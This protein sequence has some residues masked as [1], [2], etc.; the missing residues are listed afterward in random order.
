VLNWGGGSSC[1]GRP[2]SGDYM[3][4]PS[5]TGP[6]ALPWG[7]PEYL[8]LGFLSFATIILIELF[9]SPAMRNASIVLGLL[10]PLIVAGPLGYMSRSTIDAAP[11][12]TF[13]WTHTFKL[14]VYGPAVLP[15]L[16]VY[17][18]LMAEAIGDCTATCEVSRQKVE[19]EEF[20][21]RIAGAVLS[22]GLGG[23][24]S[25][26]FTTAP[27]S[28]FAQNNGVIAITRIANRRAG[29][30]CC[31]WL[32]LLGI[33]GKFSGAI[34]AIP[35][36]TL[37]GVTTFLFASVAVSGLKILSTVKYTRRN[38]FILAGSLTFGLGNLLVPDWYSYLFT[39]S[40]SNQAL[41]GFLSR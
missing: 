26:L 35:N 19:G 9:G 22:D 32:I 41:S 7:S 5:N 24:L 12:I 27:Q 34:L 17:C 40:G 13:L 11:A 15:M 14:R 23:I 31:F 38:R 37:G 28:V 36:S 3:L 39:Y 2:T 33:L 18:A 21:R 8:G 6:H 20:D 29:Y 10:L 30:W 25:A 1:H 4:C 16:A